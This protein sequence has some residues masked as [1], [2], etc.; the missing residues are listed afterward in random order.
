MLL[1]RFRSA[2]KATPAACAPLA[3]LA[4]MHPRLTP[5]ESSPTI[6]DAVTTSLWWIALGV[7]VWMAASVVLWAAN[8]AA[9]GEHAPMW[10]ERVTIPGSK[11]VAQLVLATTALTVSA[12]SNSSAAPV[13][14]AVDTIPPDQTTVSIASPATALEDTEL[15]NTELQNTELQN[16][17]LDQTGLDEPGPA[18]SDSEPEL[19]TTE[20]ISEPPPLEVGI[21]PH[22][23]LE[24][25]SV[26]IDHV[27][28]PGD[29]LWSIAQAHVAEHDP[30]ATSGDVAQYWR[31]LMSANGPTLR[32]G[33]PNLIYVGETLTLPALAV[34]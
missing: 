12:C 15:Q 6:S 11:R 23:L 1:V 27:V 26:A 24:L 25:T 34:G 30:D 4:W 9:S 28:E 2:V 19:A 29:S 7:S 10:L 20:L 22:P 21:D 3:I 31:E 16:T 33:E 14:R 18:A 32:S 13:L 8:D 17:E 5:A